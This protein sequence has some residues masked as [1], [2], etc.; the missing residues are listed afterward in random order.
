[1]AR[2]NLLPW[3]E[4]LR[5]EKQQNF[6]AA[7]GAGVII[8]G[9]IMGG[10]HFYFEDRMDYQQQR[11]TYL[12]TEIKHLDKQIE[13]IKSLEKTKQGL[14]ARLDIIQRLQGSRPEIVHLFDEL[15]RT[16]PDG[17]YLTQVAQNNKLIKINGIA[18]SN[19]RIS[20]YMW[21]M[22]K[23]EWL[24]NPVLD[25]IQTAEKDGKR[26]STFTLS[27]T[28]TSKADTEGNNK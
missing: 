23:S 27:V 25:V 5:K 4:E 3:R 6:L 24:T 18:Q 16:L 8:T 13:E 2:I 9:V 1:M 14:Q 11:N 17:V 20:N 26:N 15:V 22:E 28:Q 12:Q 19:A 21:G 10:V 7:L